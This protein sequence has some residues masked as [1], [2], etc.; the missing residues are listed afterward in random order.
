[1]SKSNNLENSVDI[2]KE[3]GKRHKNV[4]RD[5]RA[6]M[7]N[8]PKGFNTDEVT[9]SAYKNEQNK[10]CTCY[11]L[12]KEN[13]DFI[14]HKYDYSIYSGRLELEMQDILFGLFPAEK[15]HY[16]YK[17]LNYRLDFYFEDLGIIVEYDEDQHTNDKS[18]E[19][20]SKRINEIQE[21]IK[22][23]IIIK[24]PH[25]EKIDAAKLT[26]C[27]RINKGDEI[28]GVRRLLILITEHTMSCCTDFT[29][30]EVFIIDENHWVISK[31]S[32][33]DEDD[34][35]IPKPSRMDLNNKEELI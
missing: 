24:D 31:P 19:Y 14:R 18:K 4:L 16:Q 2:A 27:L 30:S 11:L 35:V 15:L 21:F 22:K 32:M 8:N 17:I 13:T 3:I 34:C 20:D 1:M 7:K 12:S 10:M 28:E 25:L 33:L 23:D 5:I 29:G 9:L 6:I 26:P